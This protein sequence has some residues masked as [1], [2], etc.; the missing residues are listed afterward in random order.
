MTSLFEE[1]EVVFMGGHEVEVVLVEQNGL[2]DEMTGGCWE[3]DFNRVTMPQKAVESRQI[4]TFFHELVHGWL[5]GIPY[6]EAGEEAF[7]QVCAAGITAFIAD[8]PKLITEM[9]KRLGRS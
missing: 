1:H 8:N 9:A 5:H 6:S 7:T 3:A 2:T 4:E